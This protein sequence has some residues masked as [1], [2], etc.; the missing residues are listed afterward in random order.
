MDF[1]SEQMLVV[2]ERYDGR[3]PMEQWNNYILSGTRHHHKTSV[4]VGGKMPGPESN[5]DAGKANDGITYCI[6]MLLENRITPQKR[7]SSCRNNMNCVPLP[8]QLRPKLSATLESL[9]KQAT[10]SFNLYRLQA[11]N[12]TITQ[13]RTMASGAAPQWWDAFPKPQAT[14]DF[15]E[16]EEVKDLIEKTQA[17]G[18]DSVRD[19]LL[20]DV[21]RTDLEGG[22]VATSV[23]LP[24]QSFYVTRPAIYQLC[25][26]A[27]V[28]RIIFYCG[29]EPFLP[30]IFS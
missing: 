3:K 27:G 20:V 10:T 12:P 6:W 8:I 30:R 7:K 5:T 13:L 23:N 14:C 2:E 26:Q 29:K 28:K 19:F 17:A 24:A 4:G 9:G 16:P 22:T 25:K 15:I 11:Q 21:R 18:K 1:C